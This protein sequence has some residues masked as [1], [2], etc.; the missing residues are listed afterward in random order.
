MAER[1]RDSVNLPLLRETLHQYL[2]DT[3]ILLSMRI[4]RTGTESTIPDTDVGI[5]S[6]FDHCNILCD[7]R[8]TENSRIFIYDHIQR[9]IM[10]K[11]SVIVPVYNAGKFLPACIESI[12]NQTFRD[13]ELI[14][15]DDGSTDGGVKSAIFL[16]Q[17]ILE[18][19]LSIR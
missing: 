13:F 8:N 5:Y 4:S 11:L 15:V 17:K 9:K 16:P 18:Y 2:A 10:P 6:C 19:M 7:I 3:H 12:L 14:L 1:N